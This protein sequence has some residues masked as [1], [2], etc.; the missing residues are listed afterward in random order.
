MV[1]LKSLGIKLA[2]T[3]VVT[4]LIY[5]FV[6]LVLSNEVTYKFDD[7]PNSMNGESWF[8]S[9]LFISIFLCLFIM[10]VVMWGLYS[11]NI[12]PIAIH[13]V[14]FVVG[15]FTIPAIFLIIKF[16]LNKMVHE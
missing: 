13:I 8:F 16:S 10:D 11:F 14:S 5:L 3:T 2:A 9:T 7:W 12:P 4:L 15:L 1:V 6:V